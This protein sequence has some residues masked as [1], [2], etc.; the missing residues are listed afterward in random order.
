METRKLTP[1]EI[2]YL[3]TFI[4]QRNVKYYDVQMELVDHFASAIETHWENNPGLS[5][6]E[7]LRMEQKQFNKYDFK[8]IIEEK[9]R[10]LKKKYQKLQFQ[11]IREFFRLPK[12]ILTIISTLILYISFVN[13]NQFKKLYILLILSALTTIVIAGIVQKLRTKIVLS[14]NKSLLI[15]EE[16]KRIRNK[17]MAPVSL[18]YVFFLTPVN[19]IGKEVFFSNAQNPIIS[20]LIAL[21]LVLLL[22]FSYVSLIYLPQRIKADFIREYP[23]FVKA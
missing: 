8:R 12:I 17:M 3:F 19:L 2:D 22:I 18:L 14:E 21:S 13:T 10:A 6:D 20:L 1:N 7:S 4:E 16:Y 15:F 11:Y 9:E 5:F 23:Q